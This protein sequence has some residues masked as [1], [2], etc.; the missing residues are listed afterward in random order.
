[1]PVNY[2]EKYAVN[3][4]EKYA[5]NYKEKYAVNYKEKYARLSNLR[6]EMLSYNLSDEQISNSHCSFVVRFCV[7]LNIKT[8]RI[9][10]L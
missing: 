8:A 9:I 7:P 4:K 1:M 6:Q 3:Y 10:S 2:K 5:V